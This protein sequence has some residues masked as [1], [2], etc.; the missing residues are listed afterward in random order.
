MNWKLS[1]E[2]GI[3]SGGARAV[4]LAVDCSK[5]GEIN[6]YEIGVSGYTPAQ[7]GQQLAE[8]ALGF[9]GF[10]TPSAAGPANGD[11]IKYLIFALKPDNGFDRGFP[12]G[13][14]EGSFGEYSQDPQKSRLNRNAT[15][16]GLANIVGYLPSVPFSGKWATYV[17]LHELLHTFGATQGGFTLST[18]RAPYSSYNG[19][20]VDGNDLMCYEDGGGHA[21]WGKYSETRCPAPYTTVSIAIDCKYDTFF[22]GA[23]PTGTWLAEY[24]DVAGPENPFLAISP[25][26]K[27]EA[28]T[29]PAGSVKSRQATLEATITPNADYAYYRFDYGTSTAYGSK[30]PVPGGSN[31]SDAM[32]GLLG[33]GTSPVAVRHDL[34]GLAPNTTY[35]Y[36]IVARNDSGEYAYGADQS[37]KT[38]R[39]PTATTEAAAADTGKASAVLKGFVE[40]NGLP[41]TYQFE[42]GESKAY[43]TS[44]PVPAKDITTGQASGNGWRVES[45]LSGLKYNTTYHARLVATNAD[46]S[47]VGEDVVFK[48]PARRPE[49]LTLTAT[50]VDSESAVLHGL[51]TPTVEG[52]LWGFEYDTTPYENKPESWHG[53]VVPTDVSAALA[54]DVE[55]K[56]IPVS[57][58]IQ[59]LQPG[60]EYHFRVGA[61][62]IWGEVFGENETFITSAEGS[63]R[64]VADRYPVVLS[65]QQS[66]SYGLKMSTKGGSVT[67]EGSTQAGEAGSATADLTLS[68]VTSGCKTDG[69]S[70]TSIDMA[71]CGFDLHV[72]NAGPPYG[73]NVDV[74]CPDGQKMKIVKKVAG[75]TKCTTT[76]GS[77]ATSGGVAL[78]NTGSGA[79]RKVEIGFDLSGIAYQQ[80]EGIGAGRCI[81]N[82]EFKDGTLTGKA[83]LS[84]KEKASG[85]A[86]GVSVRGEEVAGP[87]APRLQSGLYPA[88]LGA[89]QSESSRLTLATGAG[90]MACDASTLI[91]MADTPVDDVLLHWVTSGCKT[92]GYAGTTVEMTG[93]SL[94]LHVANAGPPYV[95]NVDVDCPV[96][97]SIKVVKK[98]AGV[99][100]CT[101]VIGAQTGPE[102]VTLNN[103]GSGVGRRVDMAF[104]LSGITYQ[105]T[106]GIGAGRCVGNGEFKDG[107]LTGQAELRGFEEGDDTGQA[108][109]VGIYLAGQAISDE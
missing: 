81:G 109:P 71:G 43:G 20:C 94:E 48:T 47:A 28:T 64:L 35:H 100:K 58:E 63:P 17:P 101:T 52:A 33:Y 37:F 86:T 89:D 90:G 21:P 55:G 2:S 84:G 108:A 50:E 23:P 82:G 42:Y 92:D 9:P 96:G 32:T 40:G 15:R 53:T 19:H 4:K 73:G 7:L 69:Y 54:P 105:Q 11:A 97:Q 85:Q 75:V 57:Y 14:R 78:N 49:V 10:P 66:E 74:A 102:G 41:T 36:R 56:Q 34:S 95:G 26:G 83:Q 61:V 31:E 29:K 13:G 67:C 22:N 6:I 60:T 27:P 62:N 38:N 99:V 5:N 30:V 72:A 68:W 70:G 104:N 106:E 80:T 103:T 1:N 16:T 51:V 24:W 44:V 12:L 88:S 46:G 98:I 76:V 107:T 3:S 8:R 87:H 93:C 45:A 25:T 18:P 77:Q 65:A 91:G 39:S 79:G 59:G